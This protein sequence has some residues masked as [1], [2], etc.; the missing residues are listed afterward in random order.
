MKLIAT[1]KPEQNQAALDPWTAVHLSSGLALGLMNVPARWAV[2]AS[3]FYEVSEQWFERRDWGK[4]F[5]ATQ[6]P[7][8]LPNAIAD[9][10]VF[11]V[12]H[13]LGQLWNDRY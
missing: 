11:M 9:T 8:S 12:G 13:R 5:F 1:R 3:I 7:E 6:G 10:V 2:G 4:R